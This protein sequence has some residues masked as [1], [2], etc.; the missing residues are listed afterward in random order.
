MTNKDYKK[1]AEMISAE[2]SVILGMY[3]RGVYNIEN[4]S[5]RESQLKSITHG[6]IDIFASDNPNFDRER[7]LKACG[8]S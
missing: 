8:L 2:K 6:M 5:H 7:F 4:A 1:F 3:E